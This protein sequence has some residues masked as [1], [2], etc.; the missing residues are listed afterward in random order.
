M[1][2]IIVLVLIFIVFVVVVEINIYYYVV[3]LVWDWYVYQVDFVNDVVDCIICFRCMV[4]DDKERKCKD[5]WKLCI[6]SGGG[7]FCGFNEFVVYLINKLDWRGEFLLFG[8]DQ[9][10]IWFDM[11]EIGKYLYVNQKG[12]NIC[13]NDVLKIEVKNFSIQREVML[14]EQKVLCG[15]RFSFWF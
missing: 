7:G 6:G 5:E 10:D 8:N 12:F 15:M 2:F 13:V 4:Y 9:M 3:Y 1:K 11:V 14:N